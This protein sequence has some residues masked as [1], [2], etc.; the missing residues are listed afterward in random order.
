MSY[1]RADRVKVL[2]QQVASEILREL[3]DPRLGFVTITDVELS[4]DL[5]HAKIF[6][7]ILGSDEEQ[8]NTMEGLSSATGFVR[9]EIGKRIRLRHTPEIV[10]KFD[11]SIERAIRIAQLLGQV[12]KEEK[13]IE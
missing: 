5:K 2:I 9:S 4:G 8:K 6:V 12:K 11:S 7:S 1:Q 13:N 10:F 3:K